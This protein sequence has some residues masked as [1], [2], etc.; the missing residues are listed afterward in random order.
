M[1]TFEDLRLDMWETI[2]GVIAELQIPK[3]N[4][5]NWMTSHDNL[6][7]LNKTVEKLTAMGYE[8]LGVKEASRDTE[9]AITLDDIPIVTLKVHYNGDWILRSNVTEKFWD[10]PYLD[11][12]YMTINNRI[13][14]QISTMEYTIKQRL[15][16]NMN[17]QKRI[18]ELKAQKYPLPSESKEKDTDEIE[19]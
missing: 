19:R 16:D 3:N 7:I 14:I 12:V 11:A 10:K 9:N 18:A 2:K 4:I 15:I 8:K 17:D 1:K 6:T 5:Y 13:D